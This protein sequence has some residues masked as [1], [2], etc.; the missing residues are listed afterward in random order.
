MRV[1]NAFDR[2]V[3]QILKG[4]FAQNATITWP[5]TGGLSRDGTKAASTTQAVRAIVTNRNER[6][7]GAIVQTTTAIIPATQKSVI[8]ASLTVQ[9]GQARKI[10]T[11]ENI[12]GSADGAAFQK[13]TLT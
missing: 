9:G 10:A 7:N 5:A 1:A 2:P 11:S 3:A 4:R 6:I 12:G 13:V 8:G